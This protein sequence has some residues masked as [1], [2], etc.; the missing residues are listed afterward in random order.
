MPPAGCELTH[1]HPL[2]LLLPCLSSLGNLFLGFEE[3]LLCLFSK[4]SDHR[5]SEG[6]KRS[7]TQLVGTLAWK[8]QAFFFPGSAYL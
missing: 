7:K 4:F 2:Q 6:R 1:R 5:I 8:S 3:P